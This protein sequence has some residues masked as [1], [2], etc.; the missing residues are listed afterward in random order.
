MLS[1]DAARSPSTHAACHYP[2][3][4]RLA[5]PHL[6]ITRALMLHMLVRLGDTERAGQALADFGERDRQRG[7]ILIAEATLRLARDD[8]RQRPPRLAAV[9]DGS[10]P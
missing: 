3:A 5:A 1:G 6:H 8:R 9:L 7:E 2:L 4:G 10:A